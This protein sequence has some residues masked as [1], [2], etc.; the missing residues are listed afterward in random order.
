MRNVKLEMRNYCCFATNE[1]CKIRNEEWE[2]FS[3][4]SYVNISLPPLGKAFHS[5]LLL[6]PKAPSGRELSSKCE[7]EGELL[8]LCNKRGM[9]NEEWE[10]AIP[11]LPTFLG[12][13][14]FHTFCCNSI[15]NC[16][17]CIV[18]PCSWV[19]IFSHALLNFYRELYLL[20]C[21]P[22]FLDFSYFIRFV[23]FP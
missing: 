16:I 13:Y 17:C 1:K 8:L 20:Y 7:T 22:M 14:F 3:L 18:C 23:G 19:F 15:G 21:L 4:Y 12:F 6:L 9:E 5:L 2:M 11:K 10:I